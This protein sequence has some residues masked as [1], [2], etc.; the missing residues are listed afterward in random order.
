MVSV[1]LP[2]R[3]YSWRR[4]PG[5]SNSCSMASLRCLFNGKILWWSRFHLTFSMN[6]TRLGVYNSVVIRFWYS[7]Q[8]H[9]FSV[10]LRCVLLVRRNISV[11][12]RCWIRLRRRGC[13]CKS[14]CISGCVSALPSTDD[15]LTR[16][17]SS[18]T[19]GAAFK[20]WDSSRYFQV[21]DP[22]SDKPHTNLHRRTKQ[23]QSGDYRSSSDSSIYILVWRLGRWDF[24]T[25]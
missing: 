3:L 1:P 24:T 20:W 12:L 2:S 13:T 9:I 11:T 19:T 14:L 5:F 10:I 23:G 22:N 21:T 4:E 8:S 6:G 18:T 7:S 16:V 25:F 15:D 17:E